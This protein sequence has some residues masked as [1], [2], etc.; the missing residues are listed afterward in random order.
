MKEA[1]EGKGGRIREGRFGLT[2]RQVPTKGPVKCL[3][4]P[5]KVD[6]DEGGLGLC[7][8]GASCGANGG[9]SLDPMQ[10]SCSVADGLWN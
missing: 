2:P 4:V 9:V 6:R 1:R 3:Q 5:A 10:G 7:D 8:L